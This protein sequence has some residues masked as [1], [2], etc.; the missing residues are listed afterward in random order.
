LTPHIPQFIKK[1]DE[2]RI[3]STARKI[4]PDELAPAIEFLKSN[5]YKVSFG[6]NLFKSEHQFAGSDEERANDLQ[7]ALNDADVKVIW[8]AR[9]GYG[10]HRI[11][12]KIKLDAFAKNPKWIVG[13][14]DVTVLHSF[15]YN[16]TGIS[17]L[18][19]TMPVNFLNQTIE[20]FIKMIDALS[21]KRIIYEFKSDPLNRNGEA[22]GILMGGNLSILYSLTGTKYFEIPENC[23]LFIEDLDEYLYHVDRMMMNF[24]LSG[25]F[26]RISGLI[27][28][29]MSNMND[30]TIPFGKNVEEIIQDYVV[31]L[32]IPVVFNFPAGH[33]EKNFPL[34][35]GSQV[36]L[37]VNNKKSSIIFL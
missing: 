32:K 9:G 25:V 34:L 21:G 13:Y 22:T 31:G 18:H 17:T 14:S 26:D 29:G 8:M 4:S 1:G 35:L 15:I 5:G 23:I 30:N 2:I 24:K 27:V 11:V 36:K 33:I 10:T 16:R 19:A 6:K 12:D 3:I 28:G 37:K 20:S 7:D